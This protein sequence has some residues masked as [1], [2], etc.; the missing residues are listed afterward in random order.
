MLNQCNR[1]KGLDRTDRTTN[2]T[3]RAKFSGPKVLASIASTTVAFAMSR[4]VTLFEIEQATGLRGADLM[5]PDS[6]L[7]EDVV[8]N[9]W[10]SILSK[11]QGNEAL[12]VEMARAAPFSLLGGLAH[13]AQFARDLK[14][15]LGLFV[16][17]RSLLGDR[18]E[19]DFRETAAEA[20]LVGYHPLD[21]VDGGRAT[22]VGFCVVARMIDEVLHV[23]DC[24]LRAEFAHPP[25]GPV[26]AYQAFFGTPVL[27]EQDRNALVF[28]KERLA[29][30]VKHAN[31]DLFTYVETHF[32]QIVRRIHHDRFPAALAML[33]SAIVENATRGDYRSRSAAARANLSLRAAQRLARAQGRTLQGMIHEI[34]AASATELLSDPEITIE[35]VA[36]LVGYSDDRAFRRAFKRWT[37]Q[38][39]SEFRKRS[40]NGT[41]G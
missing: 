3:L 1:E 33:R 11:V 37:G 20:S 22:E 23:E 17:N 24:L 13:G 2:R 5:D 36:H 35:A 16:R 28:R 6:R 9:L 38:S 7:P 40:G 26:A 31:V 14:E 30:P 25:F 8:P 18:V 10:L 39:P 21:S 15:A 29:A 27:F 41:A 4:G 32:D 34:R 12:S 19:L